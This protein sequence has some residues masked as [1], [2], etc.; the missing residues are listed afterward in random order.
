MI[1]GTLV[2]GIHIQ[3]G[4]IIVLLGVGLGRNIRTEVEMNRVNQNEKLVFLV[5]GLCE[6]HQKTE[7]RNPKLMSS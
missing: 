2:R 5:I 7:P 4:S 1:P 3:D 6:I